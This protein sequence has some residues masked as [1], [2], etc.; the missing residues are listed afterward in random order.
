[1]IIQTVFVIPCA[2]CFIT[3]RLTE[4]MFRQYRVMFGEIFLDAMYSSTPDIPHPSPT[5]YAD[6]QTGDACDLCV[7]FFSAWSHAVARD[8][9]TWPSPCCGSWRKAAICGESCRAYGLR[10]V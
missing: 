9:N 5:G 7:H 1:M 8:A 3:T 10:V 4:G 2:W 6:R